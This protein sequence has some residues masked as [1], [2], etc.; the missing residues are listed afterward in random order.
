MRIGVDA[1]GGDF[2]PLESVK[3]AAASLKLHPSWTIVLYGLESEILSICGSEQIDPKG[4]EIVHCSEVIGMGDH[5]VKSITGKTDSSLAVGFRHL[6]EGKIDAFLSAGNTGA[7]LV[8]AL[9]SVKAIEGVSRPCL[10]SLLPR[11][12]KN[13]GLLLDVGANSDVKPEHLQQF[14]LLGSL[15]YAALYKDNYP[16]VGLLNLG[17]EAEKGSILTKAAHALLAQTDG[18]NFVG[19]AEGRDIFGE[20]VDVVV[21]DGFTGNIIIKVCEGMYYRL[22]KRGVQ[23]DYLDKFNFKHYGGSTI[24]GV[25][26]PVV[27]GHGITKADTFVKMIE[28]AA[29]QVE[30]GLI[31]QIK[32]SFLTFGAQQKAQ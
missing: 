10:T 23:D 16:K 1:M 5:P 32:K 25:N 29:E 4:F 7:M 24:I 21:C 28:V 17:E 22:A 14:A 8:G 6:A 3:G 30:S 9:M 19:N 11:E 12:H 27:V 18:I 31:E 20:E 2:A 26:A 13:P 15:Y